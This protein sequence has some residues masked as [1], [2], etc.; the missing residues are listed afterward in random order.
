[1]RD[2]VDL[3]R[4]DVRTPADTKEATM[5]AVRRTLPA[6]ADLEQQRKLAK[7]LL[8]A[9]RRDDPKARSRVRAELPDKHRI[10]LADAQFVIAREYGFASWPAL[11]ERIESMAVERLS[12][13][14]RF[15]RAV[16]DGDTAALR[17][18]L[19]ARNDLRDVVNEPT[20]AFDSPA[21]VAVT[22]RGDVELVDALLELGAD[23]NR[24]SSWWAGGFHPLHGASGAVGA[25][26]L[27]AGAIP[28]ACAA[29]RL[30]RPD[31]IARILADDPSRVHERGGDGQTPLHFA[32]S[33]EVADMLLDAGADID[34]VDVDHRSTPPQW[35]IGDVDGPEQSR[36]ELAKY[37]VSRG[38]RADIFLAAALGLTSRV[39]TI[40]RADPS[41]LALR[42]GQGEYAEKLPSSYHIYLW[43]IG[44]NLTPLHTAARFGQRATRDAMLAFA[45]PEQ[46]LIAAC[47]EALGDEARAIV[48]ANP[49]I[50]ERLS[51]ADRRALTDEAWA[52]NAP[53]VEL[54]LE[55][56]F[57]PAV[58]SI[59]G[60]TGGAALHC[61]AWEGSVPCVAAILRHPSARTLIEQRDTTYQGTPLSWCCHG[62]LHCGSPRADHAEVARLLI[63]AGAHVGA[64]MNG[65]DEVLSVVEA[66]VDRQ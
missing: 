24:R 60:P 35:M 59:T 31:L 65:S 34:A 53:A 48:R 66:A 45:T 56:G 63:A 16:R 22:G 44:A 6:R 28:D 64:N 2:S 49:G 27:A 20:F 21:L 54:M 11:K 23:P 39:E 13:V 33:R 58:P 57:D 32:R 51:G 19:P 61:A 7:E 38:A 62:S 3:F 29:A 10:V 12:P 30:D 40:L 4:A 55:L 26:L 46:R 8:A 42:T 5:S 47:H 50:V 9:F 43:T 18:L 41:L 37:L 15:K 52:A 25:R 1:L 36:I 17:A 14:E